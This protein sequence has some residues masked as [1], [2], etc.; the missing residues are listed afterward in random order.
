MLENEDATLMQEHLILE[1][2]V[3]EKEKRDMERA[4]KGS[5]F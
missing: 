4:S 1:E 5:R 2:A 3:H